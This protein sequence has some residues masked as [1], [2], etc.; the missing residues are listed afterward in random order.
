MIKISKLTIRFILGILLFS[1]VSCDKDK[2]APVITIL[3][4]NPMTYCAGIDYADPGATAM[5]NTDGDIS[6]E[7]NAEILVDT[8]KEGTNYVN[9]E[10]SDEAGNKATATRVV[11]VIFCR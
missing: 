10:V 5:D 4:D 9:Y 6:A 1:F 11:N 3:G 2:E 7:I 8:S